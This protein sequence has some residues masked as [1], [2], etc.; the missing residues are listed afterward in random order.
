M[1]AACENCGGKK[2]EYR[3]RDLW[4]CVAWFPKRS[5]VSAILW[6][7]AAVFCPRWTL[8]KIGE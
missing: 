8:K 2:C 1:K 3:G 5:V 6:M 7:V 4:P